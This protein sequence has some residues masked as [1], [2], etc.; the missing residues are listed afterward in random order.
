MIDIKI[1]D[2]LKMI[3]S[4]YK[5][6]GNIKDKVIRSVKPIINAEQ[7]SLVWVDP[8]RKDKQ[9]LIENTQAEIIIC[10]NS[11][12]ISSDLLIN[13]CFIIV[14]NP[15]ITFI[16]IVKR[17]VKKDIIFEIHPTSYIHPKAKIAQNVSIGPY[18]YIGR[19]EI[20]ENT[21]IHGNCHIYDNVKIGQEVTIFAGCVIG[22]D[23][24]GYF[25]NENEQL[26]NFPHIGGV[27]IENNVIVG[28]NTCID[29]GSLAN[30]I[31]MEGAKIDNLVH[32]AHNVIIGKNALVIAHAMVGGSTQ[33]GN[34][35]WIAPNSTLRDVISIGDNAVVGLGA[36][37]T[38]NVPNNTTVM[39]SPGRPANEFKILQ[40]KLKQIIST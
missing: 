17:L 19:C 27:E 9:E 21:I 4:E 13:K 30:T 11:I 32:I 33:I 3:D 34:N 6:V 15:K 22:S 12:V 20:Q 24:F 14:K 40:K 2:L 31:I 5:I 16:R 7:N 37:I 38:K 36:V 1:N 10:D 39:G 35:A 8:N 28:A 18:T 23:G 25:I 26:E 29:R